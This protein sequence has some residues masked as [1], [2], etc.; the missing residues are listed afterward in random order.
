[1]LIMIDNYDS[2]TFNIVQY[3]K[4]LKQELNV[5]RNDQ[6][7]VDKLFSIDFDAIIVSPGPCSPSQAG[8]S[9]KV[10]ETAAKKKHSSIRYLFRLSV[11]GGSIWR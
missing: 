2:F 6:I 10:I 1:M 11:H 5:F 4:E 7:T 9:N 3:F 8:I